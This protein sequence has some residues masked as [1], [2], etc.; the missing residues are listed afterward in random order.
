MA[1]QKI[2]KNMGILEVV[3][4]FPESVEVFQDFYVFFNHNAIN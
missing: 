3:T 1:E 4:L 2:T